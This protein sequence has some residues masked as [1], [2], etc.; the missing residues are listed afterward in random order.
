MIPRERRLGIE[1]NSTPIPALRYDPGNART[2]ASVGV[3]TRQQSAKLGSDARATLVLE[4]AGTQ[5]VLEKC[6]STGQGGGLVRPRKRKLPLSLKH[7]FPA[8][9]KTNID[10]SSGAISVLSEPC[11]KVPA[12]CNS[13]SSSP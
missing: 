4:T 2:E 1:V 11:R 8:I 3:D 5:D 9:R 13:I 12:G 7:R 6:P 10:D